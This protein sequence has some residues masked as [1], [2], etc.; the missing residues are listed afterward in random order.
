MAIAPIT[1]ITALSISALNLSRNNYD[2]SRYK[3]FQF[4]HFVIVVGDSLKL[5]QT[6]LALGN[7][8]NGYLHS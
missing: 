6:V 7:N 8:V 1:V 2:I 4:P 3:A 5:R